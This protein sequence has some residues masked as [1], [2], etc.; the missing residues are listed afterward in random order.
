MKT[1]SRW[2]FRPIVSKLIG[3]MVLALMIGGIN[4]VPAFSEGN[5][6]RMEYN[7]H[8]RY[9][10]DRYRSDRNR[11][12]HERRWDARN[13]Y[14]HRRHGYEPPPVIY[15]PPSPPGIRIFFPPI[16]IRP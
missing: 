14:E 11:Y 10:R 8:D 5:Q 9:E 6:R 2:D 12:E 15:A 7:D 16:Y 3:G 4:V 13:R 1:P